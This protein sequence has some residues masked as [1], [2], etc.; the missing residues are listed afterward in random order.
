[1]A[2]SG[3]VHS[4]SLHNPMQHGLLVPKT[5]LINAYSPEIFSDEQ[6]VS[7][8]MFVD[9]SFHPFRGKNPYEFVAHAKKYPVQIVFH[10][11]Q[12]FNENEAYLQ[13]GNFLGSIVRFLQNTSNTVFKEYQQTIIMLRNRKN[14]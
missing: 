12:F 3:P 1:M 2:L 14:T 6:Y 11:E 10:P 5:A 8:S 9:P 7:D 13:T 4:F